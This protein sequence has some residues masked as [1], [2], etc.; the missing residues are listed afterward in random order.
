MPNRRPIGDILSVVLP[1]AGGMTLGGITSG[2]VICAR[3]GKYVVAIA[4]ISSNWF[5]AF[6]IWVLFA[7]PILVATACIWETVVLI[8]MWLICPVPIR[9][10]MASISIVVLGAAAGTCFAVASTFAFELDVY[11]LPLAVSLIVLAPLLMLKLEHENE[12]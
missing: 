7:L 4:D 5:D 6:L 2:W 3:L 11:W 8:L 1:F 9:P 10:R 12:P